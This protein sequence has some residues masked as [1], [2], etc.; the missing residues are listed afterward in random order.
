MEVG[1]DLEIIN[2]ID[3][4]TTTDAIPHVIWKYLRLRENSR[5]Q[6]TRAV[7][8]NNAS[9]GL[10]TFKPIKKFLHLTIYMYL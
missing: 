7:S 3:S 9:G 4:K 8:G 2:P 1:E 10:V 5:F 6:G